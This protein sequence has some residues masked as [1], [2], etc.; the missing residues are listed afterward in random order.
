MRSNG[1]WRAVSW[2][3]RRAAG[4]WAGGGTGGRGQPGGFGQRSWLSEGTDELLLKARVGEPGIAVTSQPPQV[5]SP[6][7]VRLADEAEFPAGRL[8]GS[9]DN[10]APIPEVGADSARGATVDHD[11]LAIEHATVRVGF[12]PDLPF[13]G[14]P[15]QRERLPRD[16]SYP[17]IT[18]G[19]KDLH[20]VTT[21]KQWR[22]ETT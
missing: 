1:S 19:L 16:A 2:R 21:V 14:W 6:D 7:R 13:P 22:G 20:L 17:G 4:C 18:V 9:S 11:A 3:A 10:R 5:C 12:M 15:G 8:A